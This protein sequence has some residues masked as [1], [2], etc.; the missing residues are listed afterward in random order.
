MFWDFVSVVFIK[1]HPCITSLPASV[2]DSFVTGLL[3]R[4]YYA[5]WNSAL[6]F[7]YN[8]EIYPHTV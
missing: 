8:D 3:F 4:A 6:N 2:C 1:M 5:L 7:M